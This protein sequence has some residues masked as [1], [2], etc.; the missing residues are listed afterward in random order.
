MSARIQKIFLVLVALMIVGLVLAG[1]VFVK[2]F[3]V[4]QLATRAGNETAT[5]QNIKTIATVELQYFYSHRRTFGTFEQ[6][7]NEQLLH[8]KFS[9][10]PVSTDGYAF[11]LTVTSEPSTF[12]LNADPA[13]AQTGKKHFYL[14]SVSREIHVNSEKPADPNDPVLKE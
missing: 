4:W 11:T 1:L 12:T 13:N 9:G 3:E 5:V 10:N 6:L 7:L 8:S 2:A 14:D